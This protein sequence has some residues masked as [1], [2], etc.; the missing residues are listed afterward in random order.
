[1]E[2]YRDYLFKLFLMYISS[3]SIKEKTDAIFTIS[4]ESDQLNSLFT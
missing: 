2:N 3:L 1:M 4:S